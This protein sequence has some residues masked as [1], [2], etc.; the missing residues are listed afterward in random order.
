MGFAS[1][2]SRFVQLAPRILNF[3]SRWRTNSNARNFANAQT[4]WYL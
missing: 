2:Y 3:Y 4:F 1:P